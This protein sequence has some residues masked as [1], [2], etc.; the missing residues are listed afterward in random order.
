MKQRKEKNKKK[1]DEIFKNEKISEKNR[2]EREK[3]KK[4]R[5]KQR[6]KN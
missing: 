3:K 4:K 5:R 2:R 1:T 6:E